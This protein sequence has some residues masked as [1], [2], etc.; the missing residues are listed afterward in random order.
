[1]GKVGMPL[2]VALTG[3][4]QSPAINSLAFLLGREQTQA[5]LAKAI[6]LA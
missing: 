3:R 6:E 1:M 5:R 2:R 4:G